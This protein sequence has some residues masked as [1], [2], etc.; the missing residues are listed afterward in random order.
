VTFHVDREKMASNSEKS[1]VARWTD[2]RGSD[3]FFYMGDR[4]APNRTND[5]ERNWGLGCE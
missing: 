2:Y 4:P 3:G 1:V 5:P